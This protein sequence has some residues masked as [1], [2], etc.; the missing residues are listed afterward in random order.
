MARAK[1]AELKISMFLR[2]YLSDN[3]PAGIIIAVEHTPPMK[4]TRLI[5][6]TLA[7]RSLRKSGNKG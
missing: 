6:T 2:R 5:S 4:S 1:R 7:P 3:N